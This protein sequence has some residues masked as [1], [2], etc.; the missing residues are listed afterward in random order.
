MAEYTILKVLFVEKCTKLGISLQEFFNKYEVDSDGKL[1]QAEL[2]KMYE[3]N[4]R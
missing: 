4:L 1:S 3:D 2:T